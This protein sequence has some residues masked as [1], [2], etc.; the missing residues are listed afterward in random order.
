[1]SGTL[2]EEDLVVTGNIE[3]ENADISVKGRVVGDITAQSVKIENGGEVQ[4]TVTAQTVNILGRQSG[5]VICKS[6]SLG[7]DSD[8][9]SKIAAENLKTEIGAKIV[10]DL[11]VG[12]A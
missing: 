5:N 2:I 4:G 11:K 10:G 6:L 7:Q 8:V 3:S 9:N 12:K 1:M